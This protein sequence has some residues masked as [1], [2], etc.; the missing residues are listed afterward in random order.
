MRALTD[1][2]RFP[3]GVGTI[4]MVDGG[5]VVA[6]E[7]QYKCRVLVLTGSVTADS[8]VELPFRRGADWIVDDQT[9][10]SSGAAISIVSPGYEGVEI[11]AGAATHVFLGNRAEI[12]TVSAASGLE[13][14]GGGFGQR[15]VDIANADATVTIAPTTTVLVLRSTPNLTANR[16]VTILGGAPGRV[17]KCFAATRDDPFSIHIDTPVGAFALGNYTQ[18]DLTYI[19]FTPFGGSPMWVGGLLAGAS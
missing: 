2:F 8:V 19:D 4:A 10:R 18:W 9:S 7:E 1:L 3:S 13:P 16:T 5:T 15:I 11:K 6:T 17:V 14:G 12:Q